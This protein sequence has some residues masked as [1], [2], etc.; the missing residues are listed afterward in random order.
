MYINLFIHSQRVNVK[1]QFF[2][3]DGEFNINQMVRWREGVK[4]IVNFFNEG[5]G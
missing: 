5:K 1:N 2:Y 3:W 4:F